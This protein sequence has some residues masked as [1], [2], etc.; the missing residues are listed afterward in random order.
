MATSGGTTTFTV[1][2]APTVSGARSVG[3]Q[4]ANT[5]ENEASFTLTLTGTGLSSADDTDGDG[6][7]DVAEL[8]LAPLGFDWQSPQTALVSTYFTHAAEAGLYTAA[9]LQTLHPGTPLIARDPAT[10]RFR[11]TLDWQRT[12]N[13]SAAF[14]D[15]PAPPA[16]TVTIAPSGDVIFEFPDSSPTVFY[17]LRAE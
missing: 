11:L 10:G 1:R 2:F 13:L 9:Q 5:D 12:T 15:F 16:S 4:I 3:I 17:R 6:L 14:E 8:K 7:N